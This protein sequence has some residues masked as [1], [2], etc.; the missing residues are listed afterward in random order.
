MN[1]QAIATQLKGL[2]NAD[3]AAF[4]AGQKS[5]FVTS[6]VRNELIKRAYEIDNSLETKTS[7]EFSMTTAS[8]AIA[9]I[10]LLSRD[11]M[12]PSLF[13]KAAMDIKNGNLTLVYQINTASLTD[14]YRIKLNEQLGINLPIKEV[15]NKDVVS[16]ER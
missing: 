7:V 5:N 13:K 4:N 12:Y 1:T 9:S 2:K 10:A 14:D 11:G 3:L 8:Y 16:V 15:E 6:F